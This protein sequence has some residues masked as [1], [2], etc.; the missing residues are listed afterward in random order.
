MAIDYTLQAGENLNDYYL[1][2]QGQTQQQALTQTQPTSGVV[3]STQARDT[4]NQNLTYLNNLETGTPKVSTQPTTTNQTGT[5][6]TPTVQGQPLNI[7]TANQ[8]LQNIISQT[9][10]LLKNYTAIGGTITPAMQQQIASIQGLDSQIQTATVEARDAATNNQLGLFNELI[11]SIKENQAARD[12]QISQFQANLQPLREKY[13]QSLLPSGEEQDL[14]KQLVELR[15]TQSDF[16]LSLQEGVEKEFGRGRPLALST[17][18]AR[19]L[20]RQAQFERQ[21]LR[22]QETLLLDRLGIAQGNRELQSQIAEKG[23]AFAMQDQEFAQEMFDKQERREQETIDL[24]FKYNALQR[25]TAA[26]IMDSLAGQ[27]PSKFSPQTIAQ[28]SQIAAQRGIDVRDI[29]AGLQ[30]QYDRNI[31]DQQMAELDITRKQ[32]DIQKSL[33]DIEKTKKE[34]ELLAGGSIDLGAGEQAQAQD[35]RN[36]ILQL[37]AGQQD[38][39][40]GA[41]A[42]FKNAQSLIDLLDAGVSTGPIT[43]RIATGVTGPFG[44]PLLPGTKTLGLSNEETN[45]FIAGSTAF[46]ANFIKAISGVQ[47]SDRERQ[48]LLEALPSINNQENVNRTNLKT[49]TDF[50]KQK[51]ELQ[52]GVNFDDYPD[53]VP[54][55]ISQ[56]KSITDFSNILGTTGGTTTNPFA[57]L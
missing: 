7:S 52:L 31:L 4:T 26:D 12:A 44:I 19:E 29:I 22:N 24:F 43:G 39:A 46:T 57:G 21:D 38:A 45:Q 32:V 9:N 13:L 28:L 5:T 35:L 8:T 50:L 15:K 37:S 55:V 11:K 20:E 1:R 47:V 3:S 23:L 14:Q 6:G 49:L 25:Q 16:E 17:G 27:D 48:F 34:L 51:Y 40:F 2:T 36:R 54:N 30:T 53:V 41:I 42:T 33:F 56:P 18:R 10:E